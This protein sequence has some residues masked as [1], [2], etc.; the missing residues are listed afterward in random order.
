MVGHSTVRGDAEIDL[1]GPRGIGGFGGFK[2][3]GSTRE[4]TAAARAPLAEHDRSLPHESL[5]VLTEPVPVGFPVP[6]KGVATAHHWL[7]ALGT[8][9]GPDVPLHHGRPP[10]TRTGARSGE[11]D[12]R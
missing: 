10:S 9:S 2:V 7:S 6:S 11:F 5:P 4:G 8:P 1:R 3:V 12:G